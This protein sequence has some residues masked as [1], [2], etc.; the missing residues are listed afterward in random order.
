MALAQPT[1]PHDM[2]NLPGVGQGKLDR[3]GKDF[4]NVVRRHLMDSA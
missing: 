1:H 4:L 2:L 3:Y